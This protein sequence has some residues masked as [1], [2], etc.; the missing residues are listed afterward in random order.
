VTRSASAAPSAASDSGWVPLE[1]VLSLSRAGR[2]SSSEDELEDPVA[3][4]PP[5]RHFGSDA[6]LVADTRP[7]DSFLVAVLFTSGSTG[8]P[9]GASFTE[10][11][12]MPT[13]GV[14][15]IQ[16][17]VR[18]DFQAHDPSFVLSLLSTLQVCAC[19]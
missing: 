18:F 2:P 11:L 5:S 13:E 9:K 19:L 14:A 6:D 10:A 7:P 4:P 15:G 17:F 12:A 16:P 3:P 8:V 1:R